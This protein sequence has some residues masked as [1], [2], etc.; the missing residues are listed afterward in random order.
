MTEPTT[1]TLRTEYGSW[2]KIATGL[3]KQL[4]AMTAKRDEWKRKYADSVSDWQD[5]V[6]MRDAARAEASEYRRERDIAITREHETRGQ[7]EAMTAA[8][9]ELQ[10]ESAAMGEQ[11]VRLTGRVD[12]ARKAINE[13]MEHAPMDLAWLFA[14]KDMTHNWLKIAEGRE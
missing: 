12:E 14:H 11:I 3:R 10:R 7:L 6:E 1:L 9:A 5:M 8:H 2:Q 4:A 13:I